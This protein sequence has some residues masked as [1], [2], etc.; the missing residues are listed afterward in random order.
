MV[1]K[2]NTEIVRRRVR[3]ALVVFLIAAIAFLQLLEIAPVDSLRYAYFDLAQRILPEPQPS[4]PITVVD[5]N[6]RSIETFGQWPWPRDR[7]AEMISMLA[8]HK[9]AVIGIDIIFSEPDRLSPENLLSGYEVS[10]FV[11]KQLSELP[12]NDQALADGLQLAPTVLALA[13]AMKKIKTG[14]A[15]V[16]RTPVNLKLGWQATPRLRRYPALL[17]SLPL[18]E[19]S[20]AG[21]GIASVE[22]DGDGVVRRLPA[23]VLVEDTLIPSFAVE[24]ARLY[25]GAKAVELEIDGAGVSGLSIAGR[26]F[27]TDTGGN[28]WLRAAAAS[29]MKRLSAAQV[30]FD[31]Y[32][33]ADIKDRIILFGAT[34]TGLSASFVSATGNM[35]TA[36]DAQAL[37]VENLLGGIYLQRSQ[38]MSFLELLATLVGCIGIMLLRGRLRSYGG[39]AVVLAYAAF[40]FIAGLFVFEMLRMIFD[41]SASIVAMLVLYLLFI[42]GEIVATQRDRR[43]TDDARRTAL[44]LAESASHAKTNFLTGM[45]HE[46]RTPLNAIIGFSEMIKDGVLGPVSP[47]NYANYA[48]DINNAAVHLLGIVTQI[49]DMANLEAGEMRLRVTEFDLKEVLDESIETIRSAGPDDRHSIVF[50]DPVIMP[51]LRADRRMVN[52]MLLNL[53]L[54]AAKFSPDGGVIRISTHISGSGDFLFSVTDAGSGMSQKQVAE[55]FEMFQTSDQT[56]SDS[57]RGIGLGLPITTAMIEEHGGTIDVVSRAGQGTRMTLSF[58]ANRIVRNET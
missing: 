27:R 16:S 12:T 18:L 49:L 28:I 51:V 43:R 40:L 22:L 32:E 30:L 55:A 29:G 36:L 33:P 57:T 17:S 3:S 19:A 31:R 20:S 42:G 37:F 53:L 34:G 26:E 50:T 44:M 56:V 11:L 6:N 15:A 8:K 35:L 23:I 58:P 39:Q 52:Q 54:N 48:K 46:L 2:I 47:P 41:P 38:L 24:I 21:S 4:A 9:P 13:P 10:P 5:I 45:S 25:L 1:S 7:I 14:R